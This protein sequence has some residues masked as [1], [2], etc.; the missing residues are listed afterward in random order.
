VLTSKSPNTLNSNE[1]TGA[2]SNARRQ[3]REH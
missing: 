1:E 2:T 3:A